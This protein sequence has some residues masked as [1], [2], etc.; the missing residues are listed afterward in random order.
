MPPAA[1]RRARSPCGPARRAP[2]GAGAAG[3]GDGAPAVSAYALA[4]G[5]GE[6]AFLFELRD[7]SRARVEEL[8]RHLRP[9]P[10]VA[11]REQLRGRRELRG[12]LLGDGRVDRPVALL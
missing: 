8:G 3:A 9:D 5:S 11:D 4:G 12:E 10:E 2:E 6:P 1:A 7:R